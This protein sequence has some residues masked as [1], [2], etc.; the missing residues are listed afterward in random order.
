MTHYVKGF[1]SLKLTTAAGSPLGKTGNDSISQL[2]VQT[3]NGDVSW[4]SPSSLQDPPPPLLLL[5]LPDKLLSF[6]FLVTLRCW[7]AV[8]G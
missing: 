5:R 8:R 2:P 1:C 7:E 4:Q 3:G 6:P